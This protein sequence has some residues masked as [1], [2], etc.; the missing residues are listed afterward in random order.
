VV[1]FLQIIPEAKRRQYKAALD[2]YE[3]AL[4]EEAGPRSGDASPD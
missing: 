3:A 1:V 2:A 4:R